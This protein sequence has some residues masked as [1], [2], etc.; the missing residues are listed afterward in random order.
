MHFTPT[1]FARLLEPLDR[2]LVSRT[3][4]KHNGNHGVGNGPGA[5][6]CQRHLKALVFAQ[7]TGL[8]SLREIEQ[9]LAARPEALYHLALRLPKRSTLADA[10][11]KRPVEGWRHT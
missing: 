5:W 9:A 10:S 8:S 4:D 7:L 1:A 6:T 2:R 3:V 11:A